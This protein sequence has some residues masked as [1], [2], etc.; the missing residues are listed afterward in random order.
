MTNEMAIAEQSISSQSK[1]ALYVSEHCPYPGR[2]RINYIKFGLWN[3]DA[4]KWRVENS[5]PPLYLYAIM[6]PREELA[7]SD[8][9]FSLPKE[10][11]LHCEIQF[12]ESM[13]AQG[14]TLE[15]LWRTLP[16]G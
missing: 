1:G 7:T 4:A 3:D 11:A 8:L 10:S 9:D 13:A 5:A 14:R 16:G 15:L 2:R 12:A 6:S